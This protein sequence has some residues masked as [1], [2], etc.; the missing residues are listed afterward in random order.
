MDA[1]NAARLRA[2]NDALRCH[3]RGGR[4]FVTAGLLALGTDLAARILA[5]VRAFN[6][7]TAD[8]DPYGEHDCALLCVEGHKVLFKI[9]YYDRALTGLSP[10]PADS[11][12][13]ERVMTVMLAE[14][15]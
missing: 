10:N 11:A 13:T 2:L 5:A 8:N 12:V 4:L 14:E 6:A 7:F 15:Y 1:E 9:D 3:G